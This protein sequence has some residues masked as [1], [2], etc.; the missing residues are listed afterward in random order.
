MNNSS[1]IHND[2][3]N[4]VVNATIE[5]L[6]SIENEERRKL[7]NA[8]K[9]T[10]EVLN[11]PNNPKLLLSRREYKDQSLIPV[12]LKGERHGKTRFSLEFLP[13]QVLETKK[14]FLYPQE[15][16]I[17][18]QKTIVQR[19]S[20]AHRI[21]LAFMFIAGKFGTKNNDKF[22]YSTDGEHFTKAYKSKD[23]VPQGEATISHKEALAVLEEDAKLNPSAYVSPAYG[24]AQTKVFR[25]SKPSPQYEHY[26]SSW[27]IISKK[28]EESNK[29]TPPHSG[30]TD[31]RAYY[32]CQE[33][34]Q[35]FSK[36]H[37]NKE[38]KL[39]WPTS[40]VK[41]LTYLLELC[42][43][44]ILGQASRTLGNGSQYYA[45]I[46]EK[47]SDPLKGPEGI[48][49]KAL[50]AQGE[51]KT[52]ASKKACDG[53]KHVWVEDIDGIQEGPDLNKPY[54]TNPC[55]PKALTS[56]SLQD[57]SILINLIKT[58]TGT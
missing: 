44:L 18:A 23:D 9:R 43:E 51:D 40:Q 45:V 16:V 21:K 6:H 31:K 13:K 12:I 57:C 52:Q 27:I 37:D 30:S 4:N 17:V 19:S 22:C 25:V 11:N 49:Y 2:L 28:L 5:W 20:Y 54:K 48:L 34:Y 3:R 38:Y 41:S 42:K 24:V 32:Q 26:K 1:H 33:V 53:V 50:I 35:E 58:Q 8:L 15:A 39:V 47:N 10:K 55:H 36:L 56:L 46:F 14:D 7:V 29:S